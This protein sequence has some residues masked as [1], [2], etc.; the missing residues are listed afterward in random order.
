MLRSFDDTIRVSDLL[1]LVG[2]VSIAAI[3][4]LVLSLYLH[5]QHPLWIIGPGLVGLGFVVSFAVVKIS[6]GTIPEAEPKPTQ[7]H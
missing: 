7:A 1:L 2:P 5:G 3:L 4:S 6:R